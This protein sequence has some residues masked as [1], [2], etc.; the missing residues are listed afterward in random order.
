[1]KKI[2]PIVLAVV[3]PLVGYMGPHLWFRHKTRR[4]AV[5]A[6][7][8]IEALL[9]EMLKLVAA[10]K[11]PLDKLVGMNET[12]VFNDA[13]RARDISLHVGEDSY[14]L[15]V[16]IRLVGKQAGQVSV[17]VSRHRGDNILRVSWPDLAE[18]YPAEPWLTERLERLDLL[19]GTASRMRGMK[20]NLARH[21]I[22]IDDD[23]GGGT[24]TSN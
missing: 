24:P 1:M 6:R 12:K 13:R 18:Y 17:S 5:E 23:D 14:H 21:G 11:G 8:K 19:I 4:K 10:H 7:P 15:D 2:W 20:R 9:D 22:K 16:S 3:S